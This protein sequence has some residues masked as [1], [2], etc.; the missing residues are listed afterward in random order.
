MKNNLVLY[1][2][3][4]GGSAEE[5]KHYEKLFPEY[6]VAALNYKSCTP[7][8]FSDEIKPQIC[9]FLQN[10]R[11]ITLIANS[12]GAYFA[13]DG[14]PQNQIK[15][16]FLISPIVDMEK[17]ICD[18]MVWAGTSERELEEKREI[19]T[20]FGE[21]LSWEYLD[22]ARKRK[23]NW[24]VPTEILYGEKDN[25]T[26]RQTVAEFAKQ[27]GAGFTVMQNGE[28]WFHTEEQMDFLDN[29]IKA[30]SNDCKK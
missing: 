14:M 10:Y 3:G 8:E 28:H 17:L 4:K 18:M 6:D 26:S 29:W 25:L 7:W 2:H 21:T 11:N 1:I 15:K 5:A 12:I 20:D 13:M 9:D 30:K 16:A 23:I 19:R 22:Y 27:C 24:H